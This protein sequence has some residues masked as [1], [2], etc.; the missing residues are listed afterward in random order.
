MAVIAHLRIF[1]STKK[2][3]KNYMRYTE[4]LMRITLSGEKLQQP[5]I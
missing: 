5:V 4:N 1:P 2:G 3:E